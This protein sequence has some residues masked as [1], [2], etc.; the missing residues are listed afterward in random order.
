VILEGKV[1]A[2]TGA[3][4]GIGRAAA[5]LAARSG[6]RGLVLAD[7]AADA[8]ADAAAAASA[9]GSQVIGM[10]KVAAKQA[11]RRLVHERRDPRRRR[12]PLRLSVSQ[13]ARRLGRTG[14]AGPPA[15]RTNQA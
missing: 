14:S 8:L 4:S 13:L 7:L 1:V 3:A 15:S 11:G 2:V 5:M 12:R 6:A 9:A 10:T